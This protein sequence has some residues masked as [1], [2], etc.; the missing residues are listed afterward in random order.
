M[1]IKDGFVLRTVAGSNVVVPVGDRALDFNGVITL[2]GTGMFLWRLLE[3]ET[4][5]AAL[6]AALVEEYKIDE[7]LAQDCVAEFVGKLKENDFLA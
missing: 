3:S 1:R 4:D 7:A 2:N 6:S 5:E